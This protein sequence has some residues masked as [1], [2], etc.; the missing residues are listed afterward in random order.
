[1]RIYIIDHTFHYE[2]ENLTRVFFPNEKLEMVKENISVPSDKDGTYIVTRICSA[3]TGKNIS[4]RVCF[5]QY[6]KE[7]CRNVDFIA[8]SE[9]YISEQERVMAVCLYEL[10]REYTGITPPWGILTGVRP[11][12]LFRRMSDE[13]GTEYTKG[14]FRNKLMVTEE[15]I[16]LSEETEANER[17]IINTSSDNSYSLYVSIP[18]CP[19]RC[20]YCSFVSQSTEKSKALTEPYTELLCRE[21][22]Y[23]SRIMSELN[24]KLETVYIGGGTPTTL[25]AEQLKNLMSAINRHF[26]MK[27]CREFTVEAGRPD[28]ITEE[29]LIAIL[30]GGADRISINPQTMNDRILESIGRRHTS[31]QTIDAF[32]L[33]RKT[34]FGH[35]NTDLIAGLPDESFESFQ[36]T[37]GIITDLNPESITVHT[38]SMKR[39]SGLTS[40]GMQIF[41]EAAETA[42]KMHS[43][44]RE[45][46]HE[47]GYRPYYLYR[48]SRMVGNLEN[49]GYA[50][51]GFDGLYNVFIM[52]ETHSIIAC[53]AG[54]VTKLKDNR[55][56]SIQR[57]FN[58]K[59]PY[60]YIS[61]FDE[62]LSRK[63]SIRQFRGFTSDNHAKLIK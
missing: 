52:D 29:K 36:N 51:K 19:T 60:E 31:Q 22:E 44:C 46:M 62:M 14:Y 1:M 63:N 42:S 16:L 54:A 12:K 50:K 2:L 27:D 4:V 61:G 10:L 59:Y 32:R 15:K 35:I 49:T 41:R 37:L 30:E 48:Q 55:D 25:S 57:I 17:A 34:G 23:T 7:L 5:P 20:S 11:I 56:N 21:L 3:D 38:L 39:S 45:V 53:G 24:M 58:Y 43:F 33:A 47:K 9:E 13:Y 26:P 6:D 40:Q 8:D 28:T 18:F